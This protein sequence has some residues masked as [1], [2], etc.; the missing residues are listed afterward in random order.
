MLQNFFLLINDLKQTTPYNFDKAHNFIKNTLNHEI[1]HD[2][3]DFESPQT[4]P[5][6][7]TAMEREIKDRLAG[8]HNLP[9]RRRRQKNRIGQIGLQ[10]EG[11]IEGGLEREHETR[12]GRRRCESKYSKKMFYMHK[13][14]KCE[15]QCT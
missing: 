12:P 13:I 15:N 8:Q 10:R 6:A 4:D 11:Q 1:R 3:S 2:L 14:K 7:K 5:T 9:T